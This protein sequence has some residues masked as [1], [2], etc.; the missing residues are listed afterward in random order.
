MRSWVRL[1]TCPVVFGSILGLTTILFCIFNDAGAFGHLL[2]FLGVFRMRLGSLGVP[3]E[4]A[5]VSEMTLTKFC[6]Y[7]FISGIEVRAPGRQSGEVRHAEMCGNERFQ[8]I[9]CS[10]EGDRADV[11]YGIRTQELNPSKKRK[12]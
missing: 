9:T 7:T 3:F 8:S 11:R 10:F 5:P 4:S 12:T 2:D 1:P 6:S